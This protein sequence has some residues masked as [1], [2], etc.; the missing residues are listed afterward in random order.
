[1]IKSKDTEKN[2]INT[3]AVLA[4]RVYFHYEYIRLINIT[5][6]KTISNLELKH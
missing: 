1:M 2:V 5:A 3:I 6:H 4:V